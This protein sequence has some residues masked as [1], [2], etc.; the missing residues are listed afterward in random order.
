MARWRSTL[1]KMDT[2]PSLSVVGGTAAAIVIHHSAEK[3]RGS[4]GP[5]ASVS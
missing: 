4:Y 2:M 5:I 1:L 3:D